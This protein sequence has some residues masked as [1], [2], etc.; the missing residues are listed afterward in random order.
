MSAETVATPSRWG[1]DWRRAEFL[2]TGLAF[3]GFLTLPIHINTIYSGLPAHPLFVHVPV[4]L[5][6]T[7]VIAAVVF[8]S[9]SGSRA[10]GSPWPS[11][12]SWR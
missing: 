4:I 5:I 11:P 3:L 7:T 2:L 6:P 9:R 12:R 8:V 1:V 10:T